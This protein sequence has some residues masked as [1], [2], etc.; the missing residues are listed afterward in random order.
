MRPST[1]L[2]LLL[3][4][5]TLIA[6]EGSDA[7]DGYYDTSRADEEACI[8]GDGV[9]KTEDAKW[10]EREFDSCILAS[11]SYVTGPYEVGAL[12]AALTC[13]RIVAKKAFS[14]RENPC[15]WSVDIESKDPVRGC[16]VS[17][18]HR[19]KPSSGLC[20][21]ASQ[22]DTSDPYIRAE[23]EHCTTAWD[24]KGEAHIDPVCCVGT[25]FG[26]PYLGGWTSLP[27][28]DYPGKNPAPRECPGE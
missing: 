6:C 5:S 15:K 22:C 14:E 19:E 4:S 9:C 1:L 24:F 2:I 26:T 20:V 12:E 23:A 28:A 10:C 21:K 25:D 11:E 27:D 17:G 3:S 8:E 7:G 16:L 18:G 13:R